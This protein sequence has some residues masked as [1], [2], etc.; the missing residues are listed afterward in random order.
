MP[1]LSTLLPIFAFATASIGF[2]GVAWHRWG[3]NALTGWGGRLA[4]AMLGILGGI[5]LLVAGQ[6]HRG[7]LPFGF[8]LAALV[9]A[10]L[11]EHPQS[12]RTFITINS[13]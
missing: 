3:G 11:W 10:V 4:V 13:R 5:T 12:D 6:P 1:T 7:I 9:L 8:L 2:L